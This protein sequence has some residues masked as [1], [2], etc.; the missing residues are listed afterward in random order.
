MV[1]PALVLQDL[2][3]LSWLNRFITPVQAGC[4]R[5]FRD[6][7]N[8]DTVIKTTAAD[9]PTWDRARAENLCLAQLSAQRTTVASLVGTSSATVG[10]RFVASCVLAVI[11][12]ISMA[13]A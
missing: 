9:C 1:H 12:S 7:N 4:P 10:A 3:R 13:R 6:M 11:A 8:D 2:I 5:F